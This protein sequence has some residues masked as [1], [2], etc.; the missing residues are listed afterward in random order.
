MEEEGVIGMGHTSLP[1][2]R[3]SDRKE[4]MLLVE[5][6][7]SYGFELVHAILAK[8]SYEAFVARDRSEAQ[9]FLSIL[10][11]ILLIIEYHLPGMN[12][13]EVYD[14]L[15]G[16]EAFAH[17]P[18]IMLLSYDLR[19]QREASRRRIKSLKKPFTPQQL[20]DV[21]ETILS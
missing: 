16:Q 2:L 7:L 5:P 10:T 12:G 3:A 13:F 9:A 21:I 1:L 8:T 11:P 18:A 20:V 15:H 4:S 19:Q 6:D 14:L 17:L